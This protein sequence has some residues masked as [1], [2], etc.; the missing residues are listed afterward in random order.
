LLD[1]LRGDLKKYRGRFGIGTCTSGQPL[2]QFINE[3]SNIRQIS[4]AIKADQQRLGY[5][6]II[7][8]M[9]EHAMHSQIPQILVGFGF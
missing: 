1:E 5:T 8:L 3:E 9:S 7:Y 6:P 4:Y 2:S